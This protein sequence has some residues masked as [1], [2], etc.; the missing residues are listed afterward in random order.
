M[1]STEFKY[2]DGLPDLRPGEPFFF[3]RA[4]DV[5]APFAVLAYAQLLR[6]AVAGHASGARSMAGQPTDPD[7]VILER[8]NELREL[9]ENAEQRAAQMLAW[10]AAHHTK[11]PD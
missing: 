6:A 11:L 3:L 9:A 8:T 4:Q 5:L 10:Q 2:E 7:E 1:S